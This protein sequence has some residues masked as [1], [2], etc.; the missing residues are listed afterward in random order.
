VDLVCPY[1]LVFVRVDRNVLQRG[2]SNL[3][4]FEVDL[5]FTDPAIDRREVAD[6]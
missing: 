3:C 6:A 2:L 4:E 5:L 1:Y